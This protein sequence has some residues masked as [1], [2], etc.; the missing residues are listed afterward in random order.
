MVLLGM[1]LVAIS[2]GAALGTAP[3]FPTQWTHSWDNVKSLAI[4]HGSYTD[5]PSDAAVRFIGQHY[6]AVTFSGCSGASNYS[7]G[8]DSV[9]VSTAKTHQRVKAVNPKLKSMLYWKVD[10]SSM[11]DGETCSDG[12]V[13]FAKHKDWNILNDDGTLYTPP[14]YNFSSAALRLWWVDHLLHLARM[15]AT[16]DASGKTPLYDGFYLD[17]VHS[18]RCYGRGVSPARCAAVKAGRAL[19]TKTLQAELNKLGRDQ[20]ALVN[21][22]DT[23]D[24]LQA[25]V[26]VG[27]GASMVD[28]FGADQF[29]VRATGEF[30]ASSMRELFFDVVR[31]PLNA[32]RT[33]QL[34]GWPGPVV[35]GPKHYPIVNGH[36]TTPVGNAAI[37]AATAKYL[38]AALAMYLLLAEDSTWFEYGWFWRMGDQIPFPDYDRGGVHYNYTVPS[39]FYPEW[40]CPLGAPLGPPAQPDAKAKPTVWARKFPSAE[41]IVDLAS[42]NGTFVKWTSAACS[43]LN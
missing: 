40:E 20:M 7:A 34:R 32:K 43:H 27:A 10:Y 13:E 1:W 4:A 18:A 15:N 5:V 41:V 2:A 30:N 26:V 8:G 37:R 6:Q 16:F 9:E 22:E 17:G 12:N 24:A 25:E 11:V 21:G 29:L 14:F 35:A 23:L 33:L 19:V 31:N 38:N 42:R 28:H 3:T 39:A 36:D